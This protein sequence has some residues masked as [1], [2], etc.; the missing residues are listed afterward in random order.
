MEIS[1]TARIILYVIIVPFALI[2]AA[3]WFY[4]LM[5]FRGKSY[6][7]PD[8]SMDGWEHQRLC[9]GTALGD[10][11]YS[12]PLTLTASVFIFTGW[13]I[14]YYLMGLA[15][16]WCVYINIVT[17]ST[18]IRFEKPKESLL[19]WFFTYPFC[20]FL[21]AAYIAW[22]LYYFPVLFGSFH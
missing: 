7:N 2:S 10:I 16:S 8:G 1:I 6:K 22:S 18:S 9:Y 21:G 13:R 12:I 19:L 3:L 15:A 14:G 5:I 11:I 17:T 20:A 4:Q